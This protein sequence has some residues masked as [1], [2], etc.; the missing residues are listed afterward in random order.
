M[1][2]SND[3]ILSVILPVYNAEKYLGDAIESIL[4]QTFTDF[5]LLI[6][7]DGSK[8]RSPE[9]IKDY[10]A[11]D[12]RITVSNNEI[13]KGKVA[14]VNRLFKIAKGK[15]I[16]IHD[17]DDWSFKKRFMKQISFLE[18]N[19]NYKMCGCSFN[20]IS[21][22]GKIIGKKRLSSNYNEIRDAITL[23]SQF[24]GPTMVFDKSIID[25][26]GGLYRGIFIVAEDIDL[27]ERIVEKFHATNVSELL[28]NYRYHSESI[29]KRVG[30]YTPQRY[31]LKN[32]LNHLRDERKNKGVDSLWFN[33]PSNGI[34][35]IYNRWVD[36]WTLKYDELLE[37]GI[38]RSLSMSLWSVAIRLA[39][40]MVILFPL[41]GK[42]YITMAHVIKKI[43]Q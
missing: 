43:L 19:P 16:T 24:H 29:S 7:D 22:S 12:E 1:L 11:K 31:A 41:R 4:N 8:D 10:L 2:S 17:A 30:L 9:I 42:S 40:K 15:Y 28:Y 21:K 18:D 25:K 35:E 23:E 37:D 32:L 34:M 20:F 38:A 26:I 36:E 13:N 6:A 5:E 3:P 39:L 27:S 33:V 14:T